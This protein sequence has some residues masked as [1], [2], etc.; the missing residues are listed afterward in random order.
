MAGKCWQ[1]W[2]CGQGLLFELLYE[3]T[4][5]GRGHVGVLFHWECISGV[6]AFGNTGSL[7]DCSLT[8]VGSL[9][10]MAAAWLCLAVFDLAF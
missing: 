10:W 1:D 3:E 9:V 4:E 7:T 6:E 2:E 8:A 5:V